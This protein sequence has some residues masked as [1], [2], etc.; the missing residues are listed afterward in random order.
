MKRQFTS[1]F[2][3]MGDKGMENELTRIKWILKND[4][5]G[6]IIMRSWCPNMHLTLISYRI[7]N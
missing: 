1:Q 6:A 5:A 7:I 4:D 2:D 3:Q